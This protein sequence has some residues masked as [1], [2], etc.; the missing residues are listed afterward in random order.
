MCVE[1]QG[2]SP[3]GAASGADLGSSSKHYSENLEGTAGRVPR[4]LRLDEG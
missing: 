3:Y 4:Q 2:V 1:V